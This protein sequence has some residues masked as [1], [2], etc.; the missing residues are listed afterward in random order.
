MEVSPAP[1]KEHLHPSGQG[2]ENPVNSEELDQFS[3]VYIHA[4][5]LVSPEI[6]P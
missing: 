6:K 5:S 4:F 1:V 2:W 3:V